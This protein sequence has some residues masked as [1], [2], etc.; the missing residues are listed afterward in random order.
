MSEKKKRILYAA[1]AAPVSGALVA[2]ACVL[3]ED[4]VRA[5]AGIPAEL[6]D[7]AYRAAAL[8]GPFMFPAFVL[9]CWLYILPATFALRRLRPLASAAL[10]TAPIW[11]LGV[12]VLYVPAIDQLWEAVLIVGVVIALPVL[13]AALICAYLRPNNAL[14]ATCEDARA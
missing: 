10:V 14:Q 11:V 8:I 5:V 2:V 1:L 13:V 4:F 3:I 7:A 6:D 9:L 12:F